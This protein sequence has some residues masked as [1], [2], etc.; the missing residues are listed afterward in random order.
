MSNLNTITLKRLEIFT[1]CYPAQWPRRAEVALIVF[2]AALAILLPIPV[3]AQTETVLYNFTYPAPPA[4]ANCPPTGSLYGEPHSG[5]L[6]HNGHLFGT[7]VGGGAGVKGE[8]DTKAGT[9]FRLTKPKSG[10]TPWT[11]KTL[12]S[13]IDQYPTFDDGTYPCSR[14]IESNGILYGSTLYGGLY[15]FGTVFSL[16]PPGTGETAW[17]ETV[18]YNFTG[19]SDGA[20]PYGALAVDGNSFYGVSVLNPGADNSGGV[21]FQLYPSGSS[22]QEITLLSNTD[23]VLYNGDLLMDATA[24]ST[25]AVFGTTQ[26][27]GAHGYG[28]VFQLALS[29]PLS[30]RYSDLY[31]FTGGGDG[32]YP[33]GGLGGSAGDLFGTTQGGGTG[34]GEGDGILFELRQL[35]AGNPY[36]LFVQHT[37]NGPD[38]DGSSPNAGLYQDATG[39]FWGTTTL[40]GTNNLGTIFELYPDRYVVHEWHYLETYSFAGGTTDGANPESPLTEDKTGNLFGT[41]IAGGSAGQGVVFQLKP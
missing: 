5:L 25:G 20:E 10:G 35:T 17:T 33:N 39:T 26:Y 16:T 22:Y 12:Q 38:V 29:G 24:G 8:P 14:L 40:G 2:V 30:S 15:G 1:D 7:T 34:D 27:G 21:V 13:F 11:K 37:F 19:G 36:T 41:T 23:G 3:R 28:N 31:D 6:V 18:L 32:A 4:A 9:L